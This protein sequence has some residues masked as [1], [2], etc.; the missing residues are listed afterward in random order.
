MYAGRIVEQGPVD[1]VLAAPLHPYTRG[2]IGSLP[3]GRRRGAPLD[4]IPGLPP[5]PANL[6]PGC[7]FAPRC[8]RADAACDDGAR[9]GAAFRR[10]GRALL[11]SATRRLETVRMSVP[12][13]AV[14]RVSKCFVQA[15]RPCGAGRRLLGERPAR[16]TMV[17][18]LDGGRSRDRRGRGG[19]A[20]RRVGLRQVHARPHRRE[21]ACADRRRGSNSAA[22]MLGRAR[23]RRRAGRPRARSR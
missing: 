2:L 3:G 6:P 23:V 7:A 10:P 19:R 4:Q 1:A 15:A 17:H 13:V 9:H 16:A 21:Q 8:A 11:A 12:I 20:R 22:P 5:S 18:A 14:E